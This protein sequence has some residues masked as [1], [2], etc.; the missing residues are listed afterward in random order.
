M[1]H[2]RMGEGGKNKTVFKLPSLLDT[3][4][5]NAFLSPFYCLILIRCTVFIASG[6]IPEHEGSISLLSFYGQLPDH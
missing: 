2:I 1:V 3:S 5:C 4:V 6:K